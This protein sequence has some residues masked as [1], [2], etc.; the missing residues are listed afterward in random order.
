MKIEMKKNIYSQRAKDAV[1]KILRDCATPG[2]IW[3]RH[4]QGDDVID[5][6]REANRGLLKYSAKPAPFD[7]FYLA[8]QQFKIDAPRD[9]EGAV[10]AFISRVE[11]KSEDILQEKEAAPRGRRVA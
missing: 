5:I 6:W 3:N 4:L 7:T 2:T 1:K 11:A 9:F 8:I 10:S